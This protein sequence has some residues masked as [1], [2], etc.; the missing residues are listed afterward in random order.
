LKADAQLP[1]FGFAGPAVP[2]IALWES[3]TTKVALRNLRHLVNTVHNLT[4][5]GVGFKVLTRHGASI[6][7]T[8]PPGVLVFGIF[9]SL[10]EFERELISEHG[11]RQVSPQLAPAA[12]SE[13]HL[14]K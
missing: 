1:S 12:A 9:A 7:M 14:L 3:T 8:T 10:S 11:S 2:G 13:E 5:Q 4:K 6:D